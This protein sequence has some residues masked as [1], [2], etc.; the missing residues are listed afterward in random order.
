M[1]R[2]Q[3][4]CVFTAMLALCC[5]GC[6]CNRQ[7]RKAE[8]ANIELRFDN[9]ASEKIIVERVLPDDIIKIDSIILDKEGNGLLRL[10]PETDE[11]ILLRFSNNDFIPLI[12]NKNT[13]FKVTGD[14]CNI[15][16]TFH[17]EGDAESEE[18]TVYFRRLFDDMKVSDSLGERLRMYKET[19]QFLSVQNEVMAQY[20]RLYDQHKHFASS[21]VYASPDNLA[22]LFIIN[23]RIGNQRVFN[24]QTDTAIYFLMDKN[25]FGRLPENPHVIKFHEEI[26]AYR[27]ELAVKQLSAQRLTAGNK[28][29]DFSLTDIS[30]KW[31]TLSDFSDKTVL[32]S[33]WAS[34]EKG[35]PHNLEMLKIMYDDYKEKGVEFIAVSM[36]NDE[37]MW[38]EIVKKQGVKWLNA[39][40]LKS[41][42]SPLIQLYNLP[43]K[44]P[45]YYLIG[46]DGII[47]AQY[48]SMMEIDS[49]LNNSSRR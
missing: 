37:A 24:L 23:Q 27:Q 16:Q 25:L 49:I 3:Y 1:K 11:F 20:D 32:L 33:F 4:L 7:T 19:P 47:L 46:H 31:I 2:V 15:G 21:L 48:P 42:A 9:G 12:I 36:D 38:K 6:Q 28:A 8:P 29:P 40:D 10:L 22:N 44:L 41:S 18:L 14:Y 43:E 30:G 5:V 34:W 35:T 45:V 13:V 39:S 26:V 17:V